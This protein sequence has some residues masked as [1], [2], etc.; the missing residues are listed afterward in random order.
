MAPKRCLLESEPQRKC[1]A[2]CTLPCHVRCLS[3]FWHNISAYGIQRSPSN[4]IETMPNAY[5]LSYRTYFSEGRGA[6]QALSETAR[7]C[8]VAACLRLWRARKQNTR[9]TILK[10]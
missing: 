5:M 3:R 10:A 9:S 8:D 2:I 6:Q 4:L 1:S 7:C